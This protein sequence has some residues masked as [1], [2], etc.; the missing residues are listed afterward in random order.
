[1]NQAEPK[2]LE[3]V[4][5]RLGAWIAARSSR[6]S[7]LG[8][9]A[10][11]L[12]GELGLVL[13]P[14]DRRAYATGLSNINCTSPLWCG[15]SGYPCSTC[16]GGST[17]ACPSGS[18]MGISSWTACCPGFGSGY[19]C[20]TYCDCCSTTSPPSGWSC[21][22]TCA[23]QSVC[24]SGTPANGTNYCSASASVYWCTLT[25]N[26]PQTICGPPPRACDTQHCP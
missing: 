18:Q 25:T 5:T 23:N 14:V 3:S 11:V 6:R 20:V 16:T 17:N 12:V 1:M 10:A 2:G 21:S 15:M 26:N 19:R 22:S 8:R 4:V 9:V 7:F 24:V 13:L